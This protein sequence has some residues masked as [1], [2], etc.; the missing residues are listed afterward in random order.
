M[1]YVIRLQERDFEEY[2]EYSNMEAKDKRIFIRNIFLK[3]RNFDLDPSMVTT[4]P[5]APTEEKVGDVTAT[6]TEK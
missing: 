6:N 3:K 5:P 2:M 4:E 1:L